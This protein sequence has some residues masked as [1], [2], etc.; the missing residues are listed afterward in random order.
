MGARKGGPSHARHKVV[1][2]L[3]GGIQL[4]DDRGCIVSDG[5]DRRRRGPAEMLVPCRGVFKETG[6]EYQC[7]SDLSLLER[8]GDG[9]GKAFMRGPAH[10]TPAF[11]SSGRIRNTH[12]N[13]ETHV[14]PYL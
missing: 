3:D 14:G 6:G 9:L 4:G 8:P 12:S 7:L 2:C 11:R 13:S 10:L 5:H 1:D